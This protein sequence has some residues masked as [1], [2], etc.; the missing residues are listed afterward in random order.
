MRTR[1]FL[2]AGLLVALLVAGF[3]SFYASA[4]PDGLNKVAEQTGFDQTQKDSS[5]GDGPFAGYRTDGID[6]DRLSGGVA[7][8]AGVLMVA[9]LG[10]GLFW[11][12]RR[13]D[14]AA[15]DEQDS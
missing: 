1:A 2:A 6:D 10:G 3:G 12:I 14:G 7:G 15:T 5:A 4:H 13:R 9:V 8:V 11:V